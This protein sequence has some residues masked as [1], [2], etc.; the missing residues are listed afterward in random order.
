MKV[1]ELTLTSI[2]FSEIKHNVYGRYKKKTRL[3]HVIGIFSTNVVGYFISFHHHVK[4][5]KHY[6]SV[7][8]VRIIL[9]CCHFEDTLS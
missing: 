5:I 8:I 1:T 2:R 6:N 4:Q 3:V 7:Q 9:V